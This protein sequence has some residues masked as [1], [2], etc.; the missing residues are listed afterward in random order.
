[1][2]AAGHA[3]GG[4]G[5][6]L[7]VDGLRFPALAAGPPGGEPVL[8]LHGFP[9][10]PGA[11]RA[12]LDALGEAGYRAVAP[13]QRGYA[14]TARPAGVRAYRLPALVGDAL[15]MADHLGASRVHVVGHDWGGAVAWA[16]AAAHP[17]RVASVA[18][19]STPHPAAFGEVVWRSLQPLRSAY[20]AF[21]AV[22]AVPEAVL[23]AGGGA[24]LRRMLRSSGLPDDVTEEYV[25]AMREPG[26]LAGALSWYRA[27]RPADL[28]TGDVG[29]PA[30]YV[31]STGDPALGR[32]AAERTAAHVRG[33]YR[34]V[35]LDGAP[36]WIPEARPA[37]L[38][39]L[40][41]EHLAA[42]SKPGGGS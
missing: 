7:L 40:L 28:R 29:V 31:W 5:V 36:H 39:A 16:L 27:A 37:E 15:G 9:Q 32:A 20:V 30:L 22:P 12:Q 21:F 25:T 11:W 13:A 34:F 2:E 18:V 41:L 4:R 23:L 17:D 33:P 42:H 14:A 10:T 24:V 26:A 19:V 38:S 6:D 8:L 3:T 35:V 1:M